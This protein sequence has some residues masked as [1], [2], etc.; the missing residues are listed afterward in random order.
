[1]NDPIMITMERADAMRILLGLM[2]AA[3]QKFLFAYWAIGLE[4]ELSKT[5][6]M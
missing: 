1:M 4:E 3:S 2:S 5:D 6:G